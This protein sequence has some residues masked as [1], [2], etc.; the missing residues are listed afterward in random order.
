LLRRKKCGMNACHWSVKRNHRLR[1]LYLPR[2]LQR[3]TTS[4]SVAFARW[5]AA[6]ATRTTFDPGTALRSIAV[7]TATNTSAVN[8]SLKAT[9]EK[10]LGTVLAT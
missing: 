7:M 8:V 1:L 5:I 10:D 4:T 2:S 9:A 6:V 3:R